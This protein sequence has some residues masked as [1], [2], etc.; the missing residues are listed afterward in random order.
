MLC[1]DIE[2]RARPASVIDKEYRMKQNNP[3]ALLAAMTYGAVLAI[4]AYN[5][6]AM[7]R[8]PGT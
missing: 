5:T 7:T 1:A 2:F 6:A 8:K 4:S 3:M